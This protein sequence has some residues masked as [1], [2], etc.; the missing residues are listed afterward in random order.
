MAEQIKNKQSVNLTQGL[1]NNISKLQGFLKQNQQKVLN[2]NLINNQIIEVAMKYKLYSYLMI[3]GFETNNFKNVWNIIISD[4][5][6][7]VNIEKFEEA[8]ILAEDLMFSIVRIV[9]VS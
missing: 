9:E 4:I 1:W 7:Y 2:L 8:K 6:Y 3:Y 5:N